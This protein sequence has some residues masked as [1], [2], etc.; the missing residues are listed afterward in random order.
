M[1]AREAL[2][3]YYGYE[4]FRPL[5]EEIINSVLAGHDTLALL[6]TGGGKSLC[7]QIPTLVQETLC[8]VI[9]PLIALMHD[10]VEHLL[11]R[12]IR[13]AA[14]HMGMSYDEQRRV[15][16]NCQFGPYRFLYVSPER[17]ESADFRARLA[18]LPIG[19]IAVDEAHCVSQWGYDFRPSYLRIAQV[20]DSLPK[21]SHIPILALTAT[22]TP[23]VQEDIMRKL[24]VGPLRC[25]KLEVG[26]Q[27]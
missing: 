23:E 8:L 13:A 17:L 5:Q 15:L 27:E 21:D 22:A 9:T 26:S 6:P 14:I 7:F 4:S 11:A 19:L 25:W 16:D 12:E 2:K 18:Q 24:E 10:Q 20:W 3:K 1:T